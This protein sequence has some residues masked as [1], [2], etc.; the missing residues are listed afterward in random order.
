MVLKI[1]KIV[2]LAIL[3]IFVLL[4]GISLSKVD[5][6]STNKLKDAWNNLFKSSAS[7]ISL[8][9]DS[10]T[11]KI[12]EYKKDS[13]INPTTIK[14]IVKLNPAGVSTSSYLGMFFVSGISVKVY[15]YNS[16]V[17]LLDYENAF[18]FL[19]DGTIVY[20]EI[21]NPGTENEYETYHI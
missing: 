1:L 9:N 12:T 15:G 2:G 11:D 3:G 16:L 17:N 19:A 5:K 21:A 20:R 8:G 4:F 14:P 10:T 18:G 6:N 13:N 7:K